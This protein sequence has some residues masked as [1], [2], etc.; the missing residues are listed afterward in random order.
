[1]LISN[2]YSNIKEDIDIK[3]ITANSKIVRKGY[4]F[5]AIKG[6][7]HNGEKYIKEAL[8]NGAVF[9]VS[10]KLSLDY[11]YIHVKKP[12][13]ELIRL[14]KIFYSYPD[15]I[16]TVGI[17][18][19][20]G[21][22]TTSTI[23]NSI[24]N[25]FT[26]SCYIG[27]N[28]IT[29]LNKNIPTKNTT[30]APEL[31]YPTQ[32]VLKKH[33]INTCIMEISSEGI[34]DSRIEGIKFNGAIFTNLSH[35]HLNSH[36]TMSN[37]FLCKMKL[38]KKLKKDQL[39]VINADDE[40]GIRIPFYTNARIITYGIHHG[41]YKAVNISYNL[42]YTTFH[43]YLHGNWIG[44]FKTY[45]FGIY[46]V[47]NALA[48]IAYTY[49][50][51]I[52]IDDIKDGILRLDEVSGRF[53]RLSHNN[54]E[55]IIDYAH[56]PN[57]LKNLLT[58]INKVKKNKVIIITGAQGEKD[59]SKRKLMGNVAT[60]LADITIFTSE[61][62]KHESLFSIFSDLVK[63][64]ENKEYYLTLSRYDAIMLA[65]RISMPNDIILITGKGNE[66]YERIK[67]YEFYHS[68]LELLKKAIE[69]NKK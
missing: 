27:T 11:R 56:T 22:T 46:N 5:V 49:E 28:G 48:A 25:T 65:V 53:M 52:D 42:D 20:D 8:K 17:T 45:L 16:Y 15:S 41:D 4:I 23:L 58:S 32:Q 2:F 6:K 55:Y 30:V 43:V 40:F 66:R 69:E 19:T 38:F 1:M 29:Y 62:P 36:K 50:F 59:K 13:L 63:D 35:E 54:S 9:I 31:F 21:K 33:N 34:L 68:D 47:Y 12:R 44:M 64:I 3:G 60:T 14:L 10:K 37:Y 57:A 51:G 18:G 61:D 7:T 24:F 67:D 26:S 39:A